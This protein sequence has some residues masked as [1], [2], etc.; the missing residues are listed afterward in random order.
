[1]LAIGDVPALLGMILEVKSWFAEMETLLWN[2]EI[3]H[4]HH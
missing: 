3:P 4:T 2:L 1:M